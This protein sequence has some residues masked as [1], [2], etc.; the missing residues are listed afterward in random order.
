MKQFNVKVYDKDAVFQKNIPT[1]ILESRIKFTQ[2]LNGGQGQLQLSLNTPFD[3]VPSYIVPFNF[4]RIYKVDEDDP[5]GLLIYTGWISRIEPYSTG[6]KQGV[7]VVCLGLSSLLKLSLYKDG[8][9]F[10]V[11]HT[12]VD[13][14][15]IIE[16]IITAFQGVYPPGSGFEWIGYG[17]VA[18]I[19]A[20]GNIDSVGQNVTLELEKKTWLDGI[21]ETLKLADGGWYWFIDAGGDVFFQDKPA[22]ATHT[23]TI[24]KEIQSIKTPKAIEDITNS[25]TVKY[26]GG[27][28]DASDATSITN[29]GTREEYIDESAKLSDS[30][31]AQQVADKAVADGKDYMIEASIVVNNLYDIESIKPGDT[32]KVLNYKKGAEIVTANMLIVSTSYNNG[33]TLSLQLESKKDIGS[34]LE[35]YV[36]QQ[37]KSA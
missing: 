19:R 9:S 22:S 31:S 2:Q 15:A 16:A 11:T 3:E 5:T 10:D 18:G 6:G 4:I 33:E 17:A 28:V 36:D 26:D 7:N 8:A 24:G 30:G 32:L 25:V 34:E 35:N 12:T 37:I 1:D 27:T 20:G 21:S 29:Y 13:P 23:L 14:S